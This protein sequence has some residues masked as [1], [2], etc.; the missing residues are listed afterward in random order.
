M[1]ESIE[2]RAE[3]NT[4]RAEAQQHDVDTH[5]CFASASRLER[6]GC[7]ATPQ[8]LSWRR[9]RPLGLATIWQ[10]HCRAS[11]LLL[12]G[13]FGRVRLERQAIAD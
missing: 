7:R 12:A 8:S 1:S 13:H 6:R 10:Q 9:P 2:E 4:H 3:G 5:L 11:S